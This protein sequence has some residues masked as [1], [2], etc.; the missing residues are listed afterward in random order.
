MN[1]TPLTQA[2]LTW[3]DRR[4]PASGFHWSAAVLGVLLSGVW[5]PGHADTLALHIDNIP[6]SH[7]R[8]MI[9][10]LASEAQFKD[11][12]PA[13]AQLVLPAQAGSVRFS[14]DALPSGRYSIRVMHDLD[15]NGKLNTNMV[16]MP[17]EPW[18]FSNNAKGS[19]GPPSW[20]DAVFEVSGD[21][22]QRIELV[23]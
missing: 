18:G 10:V 3:F 12:A 17:R 21:T 5:Q 23:H 14:T 6:Q 4:L 7:G 15:G 19:F 13:A 2:L 9:Q 8:L 11:E 1:A 20:K 16:G 22:E